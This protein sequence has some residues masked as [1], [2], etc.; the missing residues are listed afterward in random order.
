MLIEIETGKFP[1][2]HTS[3]HYLK[4]TTATLKDRDNSPK[5]FKLK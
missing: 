3:V 2:I 1:S 5:D 4:C